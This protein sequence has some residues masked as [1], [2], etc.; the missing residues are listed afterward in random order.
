[1]F[2]IAVL[3]SGKSRGSNLQSMHNYFSE[4]KIPVEISFVIRTAQLA[5]IVEVCKKLN[6]KCYHIPFISAEQ[7]EENALLLI[8]SQGIQLIALAGFLKRLS[9]VFIRETAVPILNIHPALLP[10]YGGFGMYGSAVHKAVFE[11]ND[12]ISGATVHLVDSQYD[13]GQI[14]AHQKVNIEDCSSPDDI[15]RKVLAVEHNLYGKTIWEYLKSI[16]S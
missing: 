16:Y 3:C 8:H 1:M 2:K 7:F 6:I 9:P 4:N 15:S 5:P 14:I 10:A 13:H 11:S 12:R